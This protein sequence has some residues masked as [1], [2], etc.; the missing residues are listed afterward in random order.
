[1]TKA[2]LV[3]STRGVNGGYT[4]TKDAEHIKISNIIEAIEGPVALVGCVEGSE[5]P[6]AIQK[7]CRLHGRWNVVN[8]AIQT[9]L[10]DVSLADML[11]NARS[12]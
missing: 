10:D 6:C 2:D 12:A 9:A 11:P 1:M 4:L 5:E 7:V 3:R 8:K